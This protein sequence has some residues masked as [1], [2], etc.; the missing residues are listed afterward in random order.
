MRF[1]T[2]VPQAIFLEASI[3]EEGGSRL[4]EFLKEAMASETLRVS[5]CNFLWTKEESLVEEEGKGVEASDL[6]WDLIRTC[7]TVSSSVRLDQHSNA[8]A[9]WCTGMCM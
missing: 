8:A 4:R 5:F 7:S 3:L 1:L 2:T 9:I 6:W